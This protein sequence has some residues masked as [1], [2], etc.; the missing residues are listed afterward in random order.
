MGDRLV[1]GEQAVAR[2]LA[3]SARMRSRLARPG[4]FGRGSGGRRGRGRR[5]RRGRVDVDAA[6]KL[7]SQPLVGGGPARRR[8]ERPRAELAAPGG[9]GCARSVH[10]DI[11][12]CRE[13]WPKRRR[14]AF[15][16]AGTQRRARRPARSARPARG[17]SATVIGR[18]RAS[19]A[20]GR[21]RLRS[22]FSLASTRASRW[23]RRRA[24]A[25]A[26]AP[27]PAG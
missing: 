19:P 1:V 25:R 23:R 22:G 24:P 10:A 7:P 17:A 26:G 6:A 3:R 2:T 16:V 9:H 14:P 13:R 21:S 4:D 27:R 12:A 15:L 20:V 18:G 11:I 5:G 8:R